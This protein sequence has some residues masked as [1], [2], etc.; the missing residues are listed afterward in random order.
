M[1]DVHHHHQP[2]Q[3]HAAAE[4]AVEECLPVRLQ[5]LGDLGIAVAGPVDQVAGVHR[6][7]IDGAAAAGGAIPVGSA[8]CREGVCRYVSLSWCGASLTKKSNQVLTPD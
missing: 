3:R 7:G 2:A 5:V 8:S 6:R 1:A 4:I